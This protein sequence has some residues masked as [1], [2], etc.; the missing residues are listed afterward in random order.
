MG[1][2]L[3]LSIHCTSNQRVAMLIAR[4]NL[5]LY[6]HWPCMARVWCVPC[7]TSYQD[8][9]VQKLVFIADPRI[10]GALGIWCTLFFSRQKLIAEAFE[11]L[12]AAELGGVVMMTASSDICPCSQW[13]RVTRICHV[14]YSFR[15][16]RSKLSG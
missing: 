14:L 12:L 1:G 4:L 7:S 16:D 6:S 8:K 3:F 15:I 2:E 10:V 5:F 13:L 11:L 9:T